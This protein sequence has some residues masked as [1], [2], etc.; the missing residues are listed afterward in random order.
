MG[1]TPILAMS[2]MNAL[3][4]GSALDDAAALADADSEP[5][6]DL[7]ASA[8]YRRHLARVLVR[9]ALS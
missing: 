9:R 1:S 4:N 2:T 8:E 6:D 5:Q 3:N 7:N